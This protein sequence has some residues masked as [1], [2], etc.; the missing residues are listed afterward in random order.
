MPRRVPD[1]PLAYVPPRADETLEEALVRNVR[2]ALRDTMFSLRLHHLRLRRGEEV[3]VE[4]FA[5][6]D[7]PDSVKG[8]SY[9]ICTD[10]GG[11]T[12]E[13]GAGRLDVFEPT[14]SK[15]LGKFSFTVPADAPDFFTLTV[16]ASD[17]AYS[18]SYKLYCPFGD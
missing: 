14:S 8:C 3:T 15:N 12:A 18:S 1:P 10:I 13:L 17:P 7:L 9:R 6:N 16:E 5:L 2:D 4:L 11:K